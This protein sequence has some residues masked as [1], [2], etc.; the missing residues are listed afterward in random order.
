MKAL[1]G[2]EWDP[3]RSNGNIWEDL[4]E[5]GNT[6]SL[7]TQESS[8]PVEAPSPHQ[9]E[10]INPALPKGSV[11]SS[12]EEISLKE[13]AGAPWHTTPP[14]LPASRPIRRLRSQQAP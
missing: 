14:T 1:I 8:S 12:P 2:K 6:E 9:S 10:E 4:D 3:E 11:M 7:N 5:P 13:T